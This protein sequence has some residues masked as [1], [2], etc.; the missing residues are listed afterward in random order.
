LCSGKKKEVENVQPTTATTTDGEIPS[1][2]SPEFDQWVSTAGNV[3]K[4]F[5]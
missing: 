2:E 4:L 5:A 1:V 3:E